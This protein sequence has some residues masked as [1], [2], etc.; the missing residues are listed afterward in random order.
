MSD[1]PKRMREAIRH[2]LMDYSEWLENQ[3]AMVDT[4]F[5]PR[6]HDELVAD[7]LGSVDDPNGMECTA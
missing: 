1:I 6:F 3:G 7:F 5:E 4:Y 2:T